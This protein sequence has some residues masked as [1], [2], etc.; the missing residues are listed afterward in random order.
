MPD[1]SND[2]AS[3]YLNAVTFALRCRDR[4]RDPYKQ[5]VAL[6]VSS[7][8]KEQLVGD[9]GR[10]QDR[11]VMY[12]REWQHGLPLSRP[13][14]NVIAQMHGPD[15]DDWTDIRLRFVLVDGEGARGA[16]AIRVVPEKLPGGFEPM[17]D[18][19]IASIEQRA[20]KS[21]TSLDAFVEFARERD[22]ELYAAIADKPRGQWI[23]AIGV[24]IGRWLERI[25]HPD[26]FPSEKKQPTKPGAGAPTKRGQSPVP[27]KP[28][29]IKPGAEP[30]LVGDE[31][32]PF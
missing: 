30:L 26:R 1:L 8:E 16:P 31:D 9:R 2:F 20:Q 15:S 12:F 14:F 5:G 28:G 11:W 22:E 24:E 27:H 7:V 3:P 21:G 10:K 23:H 25:E 17:G 6:T 18:K 13:H 4:G 29:D 19:M 32:I